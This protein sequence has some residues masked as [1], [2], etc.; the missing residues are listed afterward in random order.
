MSVSILDYTTSYKV[1]VNI[2]H[3]DAFDSNSMI[4]GV[5][6]FV[7]HVDLPDKVYEITGL[8]L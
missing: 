5:T 1:M 7:V 3:V 4:R 8:V 2:D 6:H